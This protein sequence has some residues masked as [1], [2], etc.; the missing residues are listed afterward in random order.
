MW[1]PCLLL[2]LLVIPP[3][4]AQSAA[5]AQEPA[6]EAN[7]QAVRALLEQ[8]E[9]RMDLALWL[10]VFA[11]TAMHGAGNAAYVAGDPLSHIDP[12]G[13]DL[14]VVTGGYRGGMNVFG[15]TA[16]AVEG[17]GMFSYGNDT[18]LGSSLADYLRDQ[19]RYRD[20]QITFVRT[21]PSQD[22]AAA[23]FFASRPGMNSVGYLDNC[24]V[25]TNQG[26]AAAGLPVSG[27][28]FP[29]GVARNATVLPGAQSF[30]DPKHGSLPESVIRRL[31][32]FK[33]KLP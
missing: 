1:M 21:S 31:P 10:H 15:H 26:L 3:V 13:L 24:A 6:Y 2:C 4:W 9:S 30:Y 7:L 23:A 27:I 32:V 33:K 20:Q 16:M 28:P 17:H 25:R 14:V 29:G 12:E 5:R 11:L 8:D 18:P 19:S 22:A